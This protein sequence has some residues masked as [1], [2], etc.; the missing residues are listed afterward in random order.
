MP[1]NQKTR[2]R[3]LKKVI[4]FEFYSSENLLFSVEKM[5]KNQITR[6]IEG[7]LYRSGNKYLLVLFVK[8]FE[9]GSIK[10]FFGT[11]DRIRFDALSL[12]KTQEYGKI[13]ISKNTIHR[14]GVAL[15]KG[16]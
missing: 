2:N 3:N 5:Y 6:K 1:S 10:R 15:T 9:I 7:D 13:I 12:A 16:P 8:N 4:I 11:A 14:L